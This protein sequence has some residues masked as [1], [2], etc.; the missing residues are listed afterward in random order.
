MKQDILTLLTS[1]GAILSNDHFVLTSGRHS[2]LY[3]NKDAAYTHTETAKQI[4]KLFAEKVH[5]ISIDVVA[6]PALGGI[7]LSQ[8]TAHAL[9]KQRKREILSVY[10]EK[11][12]EKEQ[13]FTRGY[14]NVI[15][16]KKVLVIEDLTTTGGSVLKVV[17]SVRQAG[18]IVAAVGV[19]VNRNPDEV[20][21]KLFKAPF[22]SLADLPVESY[23][24]DDCQMCRKQIP[25]NIHVGHG[26]K[27]PESRKK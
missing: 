7:I 11:T 10:T 1:S 4:G 14:D 13:I 17:T 24:A 21:E 6:A 22:F 25:I 26:R 27:F 2:P 16:G 9:T 20:S 18:G 5:S 19:M 8:W 15:K 3:I 23:D 12:P